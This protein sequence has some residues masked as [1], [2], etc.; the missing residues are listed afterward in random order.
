MLQSEFEERYGSRIEPQRYSNV[1]EPIYL[2]SEQNK[3]EFV[4]EFK[5]LEGYDAYRSALALIDGLNNKIERK[6]GAVENL[7][8]TIEILQKGLKEAQE[9][10]RQKDIDYGKFLVEMAEASKDAILANTLR[11]R[12]ELAMGT[13]TYLKYKLAMGHPLSEKERTEV[14]S[15]MEGEL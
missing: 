2:H 13:K 3:D 15:Y 12:A 1:V 7:N 10:L 14:I 9:A 8:R 5:A 4:K 6:R 11:E